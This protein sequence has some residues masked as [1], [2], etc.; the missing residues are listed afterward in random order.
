MNSLTAKQ[1]AALKAMERDPSLEAYFFRK[2]SG[3]QWFDELKRRGYFSRERNPAPI[4]A[5]EPGYVTVPQ[6]PALEYLTKLGEEV[7][8][9]RNSDHAA[10]LLQV[11]RDVSTPPNSGV[12]NYRT[13]YAFALI[14]GCLPVVVLRSDD[15][16][17][18]SIW[19]GSRFDNDL[20][21][22]EIR[23]GLLTNLLDSSRPID[24][25]RAV[26]VLDQLLRPRETVSASDSDIAADDQV[27]LAVSNFELAKLF[28][29][30]APRIGEKLGARAIAMIKRHLQLPFGGGSGRYS[31][32]WRPAIEDHPQNLY[33]EDARTILLVGLR[34]VLTSYVGTNPEAAGGEVNKLFRSKQPIFKRLALYITSQHYD[35]LGD[36]FWSN[37]SPTLL[38]ELDFRHEMYSMLRNRFR[39]FQP[40]QQALVLSRITELQI[41]GETREDSRKITEGVR[42]Q[43]LHAVH[44]QGNADADRLYE[45]Y[46]GAV[47]YEPKHP[48]FPSYWSMSGGGETSGA[49]PQEILRLSDKEIIQLVAGPSAHAADANTYHSGLGQAL[50]AAVKKDP[51]RFERHL[52]DFVSASLAM[53]Y[54]LLEAYRE[55]MSGGT[56]VSVSGILRFADVVSDA[57]TFWHEPS[58]RQGGLEVNRF[59]VSGTICGLLE[60]ASKRL[61]RSE[62]ATVQPLLQRLIEKFLRWEP[63]E[64]AGESSDALTEAIN[65]PRGKCIGALFAFALA[66]CKSEQ[67]TVGNHARAWSVVQPMFDAE[68]EK[69]RD[70]NLEFSAICGSYLPQL[71]YLSTD[72][73]TANFSRLFSKQYERNWNYAVQGFAYVA[74]F[75]DQ[76]YVL[77][78]E[79]GVVMRVLSGSVSGRHVREKTLQFIAVA[80]LRDIENGPEKPGI[81]SE[82]IARRKSSELSEIIHYFW[83][84]RDSPDVGTVRPK[85]IA[86]WRHT[87][88][89][90]ATAPPAD[91]DE[92]KILSNLSLL[93]AFLESIDDESRKW[94]MQVAGL[95]DFNYNASFFMANLDRLATSSPKATAEVFLE[96]ARHKTPTFEESVVRSLVSKLYAAG[97]TEITDAICDL[98]A[99]QGHLELVRDLAERRAGR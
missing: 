33:R 22:R 34:D 98:Y 47:G 52:E 53:K 65:R 73:L 86:F 61:N 81:L 16:K 38:L 89:Q 2:A 43:W 4:P 32:I 69:C 67:K 18:V 42:L 59:W 80:Y 11:L 8:S 35:H 57:D 95:A 40:E 12:D 44:G 74:T 23:K 31:Y 27:R 55:L 26:S 39:D 14:V 77:L 46:L 58:E 48:D 99:R 97:L 29:T 9:S 64:P 15:L 71:A 45:E 70:S 85:V 72:W 66:L 25:T 92:K 79:H 78:K 83:M 10:L 5:D 82:I 17:L 91:R 6:W 50:K 63:M 36:V 19:L 30:L 49:D 84:L 7:K 13:W 56:E 76:V 3:F 24:A 96:L 21:A 88:Q 1:L 54:F 20:V 41:R 68:I 60:E 75:V 94:L 87:Y 90:F 93:A 28:E 51:R 62:L 37:F